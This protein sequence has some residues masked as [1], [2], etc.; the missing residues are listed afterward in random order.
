MAP[1]FL[2]FEPYKYIKSA[3]MRFSPG[4]GMKIFHG[5]TKFIGKEEEF[6]PFQIKNRG[7]TAS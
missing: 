1:G 6:S 4:R 3:M 2:F 5:I 7:I